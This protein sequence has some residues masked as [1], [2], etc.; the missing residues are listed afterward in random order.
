MNRKLQ[1]IL[2]RRR[3]LELN[4][5]QAALCAGICAVSYLSRIEQAKVEGTEEVLALLMQRLEIPWQADPEF[6]GETAAWFEGWYD[7]LFAGDNLSAL[8][9][10]LEKRREQYRSAP[11]WAGWRM[12]TWQ[13]TGQPPEELEEFLPV[14]DERQQKLR[15]CILGAYGDLLPKADQ[16][17]YFL[18]AG[19]HFLWQGSYGDAVNCLQNAKEKA[20]WEGS[21]PVQMESCAYLGSCYSGLNQLEQARMHYSLASRMARSLGKEKDVRVIA[22][23]LATTE[24][25][26]GLAE[27]AMHHLLDQ[28]WNE[29]LYF[30]K[31]AVAYELLGWKNKARETLARALEAPFG[32][33]P[34]GARSDDTAAIRMTFE[35]MCALV[36]MRLDDPNYLK[37]PAYGEA[38]RLCVRNQKRYLSMGFVWFQTR[39]LLEWYTAN[40]QYQK[41][42]DVLRNIYLNN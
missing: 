11:F 27:D 34:L 15:L 2:I 30:Q 37:N 25:Q 41:A 19:K 26:M 16:S 5:S 22:Y 21:L 33:A 29:G 3:R 18:E 28:P 13:T 4:W 35:Q 8:K 24:L 9:P 39:W 12:L 40:R 6:C 7:R 20:Y 36:Q 23:N 31:L 1:G 32:T 10:E 38:L 17:Y 14:L 42:Y